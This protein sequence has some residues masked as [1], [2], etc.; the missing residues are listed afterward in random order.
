MKV[1]HIITGLGKGGTEGILYNLVSNDTSNVHCIVSLTGMGSYGKKLLSSGHHVFSLGMGLGK[2]YVNASIKLVKIVKLQNPDVVQ[3]WMYHSDL[4]GGVI[5]KLFGRHPIIWN[6]RNYSLAPQTTPLG[7]RVVARLCARLSA[8]IPDWIV[9]C[10]EQASIYHVANGYSAEKLTVIPNGY[11]LFRFSPDNDNR[12]KMRRDWKV[13]ENEIII[14]MVARWDPKKDHDNLL[15]ALTLIDDDLQPWRCVLV[16]TG[17][18][19]ENQKLTTLLSQFALGET[20]QLMGE[21]ND[22]PAIMQALDLHV[23]SSRS[24]A[25]PNVLA[26]AMGC[27]TP[28]ISTAVG[29]A[30]HIV[31]GTGWLVSPKKPQLLADAITKA[32]REIRNGNGDWNKRKV[33]C[34]KRVLDLFNLSTMVHR[35][36]DIW[37]STV[38]KP[39]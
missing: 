11:D 32:M 23:L 39:D 15:Q 31:A 29:D 3:T 14:G 13:T 8:I 16:G 17:M 26:E 37:N 5:A 1:L 19:R 34:R 2:S 22:I 25:F 24:E 9:S 6:I 21:R 35:Y 18:D 28:C 27:G 30:S 4:L 33:A 36:T 20:I 12:S 7:T 38:A 10:S